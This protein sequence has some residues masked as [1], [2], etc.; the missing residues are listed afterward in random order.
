[1]PFG[2]RWDTNPK[3]RDVPEKSVPVPSVPKKSVPVPV[4]SPGLASRDSSPMGSRPHRPSLVISIF[5]FHSHCIPYTKKSNQFLIL[6]QFQ[7]NH[8][9]SRP[10]LQQLLPFSVHQLLTS[11]HYRVGS[12]ARQRPRLFPGWLSIYLEL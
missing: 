4:P 5:Y 8:H 12:N 11:M 1:M 10:L 2:T 7:S 9:L 6:I 3:S